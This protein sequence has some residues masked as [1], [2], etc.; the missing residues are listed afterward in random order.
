MRVVKQA[1]Q[2]KPK[3]SLVM[4]FLIELVPSSPSRI[5]T[6]GAVRADALV[7]KAFSW[8]GVWGFVWVYS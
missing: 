5:V 4:N 1:L 7:S 6:F 2:S 3:G 8:C